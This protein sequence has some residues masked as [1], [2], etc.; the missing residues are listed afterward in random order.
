MKDLGGLMKQAQEMQKKISEAQE[1]LDDIE[2][3]GEAG[4]GL[5]KIVMTA[6]GEAKDISIDKTA[7]DP[8][9]PEILE[10]LVKA[11]LNDAKRKS[12]EA[13]KKV[14]SEATGGMGLPPGI[15]FP[16]GKMGN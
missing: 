16:F 7:M 9:E 2:V 8:E 14:M 13:Q 12:E 3:T 11:A 10:D 1:R 6:K 5:V 4:A 15:D